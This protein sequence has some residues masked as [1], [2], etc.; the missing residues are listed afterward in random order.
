M[1]WKASILDTAVNQRFPTIWV[2]NA[3]K[4]ESRS[5]SKLLTPPPPHTHTPPPGKMDID[6]ERK[7]VVNPPT[8]RDREAWRA[9]RPDPRELEE[10]RRFAAPNREVSQGR[11]RPRSVAK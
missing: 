5:R 8:E 1:A 6:V 10:A 7:L 3:I 9:P 11:T 2:T 4:E